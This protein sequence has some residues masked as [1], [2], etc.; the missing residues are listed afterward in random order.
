MELKKIS[1]IYKIRNR[2]NGKYYIGSSDNILGT[3]GRWM[4]HINGLK[5]N[6][7]DNSYLQHS[8]NKYGQQNF[9][10]SIL[11]EV[12]KSGLFLIEQKYLDQAKKDGKKCY[13]LSF[14][15]VGGGFLGKKHSEKSKRQTSEKL[16]GRPSPM[17]GR[18]ILPEK[19]KHCDQRVYTFRHLTTN[20][21]FTGTRYQFWTRYHLHRAAISNL[22]RGVSQTSYGWVLIHCC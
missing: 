6:R 3:S 18:K 1:G 9:E 20:E 14:L 16:K 12:P 17:R 19:N 8:W 2:I 21:T 22:I 11:E 13:N 15:A 10:F 7:H 5:S 4:E